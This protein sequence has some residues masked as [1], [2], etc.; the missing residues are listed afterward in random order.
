MNIGSIFPLADAWGMHGDIGAGWWIVMVIAM[1]LFWGVVIVV[2]AR[3]LRGAFDG[4][5][6]PR[7]ESPRDILD[8]RFAEGAISVEDY[9]ERREILVD[10]APAADEAADRADRPTAGTHAAAGTQERSER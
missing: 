10:R 7:S 6:R 2:G 8:R 3:L 1:V 5:Q 9:R 4:W